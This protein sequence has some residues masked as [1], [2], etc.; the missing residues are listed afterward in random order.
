VSATWLPVLADAI[1]AELRRLGYVLWRAEPRGPDKP[2]KVP[3]RIDAPL[4]RASSTDP[5][6]WGTFAD[7][8]DAYSVL[9]E[10]PADPARGPVVG[11]GVVLTLTA[12]VTCIDLD[13]VIDGD[14]QLDTRAATV[15]ERC[16]S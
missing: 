7:A 5:A 2:A 9:A 8:V 16:D 1:P 3:Y 12:G 10:Q 13:R 14:G 6:T 4:T 15:V 11:V